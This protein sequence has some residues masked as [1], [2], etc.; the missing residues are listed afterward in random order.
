MALKSVHEEMATS[1]ISGFS[2]DLGGE[3]HNP[4]VCYV[5]CYY[6]SGPFLFACYYLLLLCWKTLVGM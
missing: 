3:G 4:V 5:S 1:E 2:Q 6:S